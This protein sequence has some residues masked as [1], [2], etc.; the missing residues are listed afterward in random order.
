MWKFEFESARLYFIEL[1]ASKKKHDKSSLVNFLISNLLVLQTIGSFKIVALALSSTSDG[2]WLEL[3]GGYNVRWIFAINNFN[4]TT[5][6]ISMQNEIATTVK[7]RVPFGEK[8]NAL[9]VVSYLAFIVITRIF[10]QL[11]AYVY[12]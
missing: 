8:S 11:I 1:R 6:L 2:T 12:M 10:C 4:C 3:D 5:I 9:T 7:V